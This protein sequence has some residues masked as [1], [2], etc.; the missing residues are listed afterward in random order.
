VDRSTFEAAYLIV[1]EIGDKLDERPSDIAR[2]PELPRLRT[3]AGGVT[4]SGLYDLP[5]LPRNPF[6]PPILV[7]MKRQQ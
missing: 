2:R 4:A 7:R 5:C 1:D 3:P 6:A